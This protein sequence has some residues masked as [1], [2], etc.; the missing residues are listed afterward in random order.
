MGRP[1]LSPA[2]GGAAHWSVFLRQLLF[3]QRLLGVWLGEERL[4]LAIALLRWTHW[5]RRDADAQPALCVR[6]A[7]GGS[8][9]AAAEVAEALQAER[10]RQRQAIAA[11]RVGWLQRSS[12]DSARLQ[13]SM[14]K[15]LAADGRIAELEDEN[16]WL[17]AQLAASRGESALAATIASSWGATPRVGR[18]EG[19]LVPAD[20]G[21]SNGEGGGGARAGGMPSSLESEL[22]ALL[23]AEQAR[24]V[25]TSAQLGALHADAEERELEA[26]AERSADL[27]AARG[28]RS[29]S[30]GVYART[31]SGAAGWRVLRSHA[32]VL[33]VSSR[34]RVRRAAL[35]RDLADLARLG[36]GRDALKW[37][38]T[39]IRSELI[40]LRAAR[41]ADDHGPAPPPPSPRAEPAVPLVSPARA[42]RRD[43]SEPSTATASPM[44]L[45]QLLRGLY[46]PAREP[47]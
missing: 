43:F 9:S 2:G 23:E 26:E 19:A 21:A 18:G 39:Q 6:C 36:G 20:A 25:Q 46:R 4:R 15:L 34:H 8:A 24:L 28:A 12:A 37:R 32:R 5:A 42:E 33:A 40:M 29:V 38:V 3:E 13:Q 47:G 35:E 14:S 22:L 31:R 41:G 44:H 45:E 7:A 27:D 16:G 30:L 11:E 17:R 1:S 10:W